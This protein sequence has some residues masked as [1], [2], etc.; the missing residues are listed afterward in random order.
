MTIKYDEY[1][2]NQNRYKL[3]SE[4]KKNQL[5]IQDKMH[6]THIIFVNP[7]PLSS[8]AKFDKATKSKVIQKRQKGLKELSSGYYVKTKSAQQHLKKLRYKGHLIFT[9]LFDMRKIYTNSVEHMSHQEISDKIGISKESLRKYLRQ[10]KTNGLIKTKGTNIYINPMIA[11]GT[12][13]HRKDLYCDYCNRPIDSYHKQPLFYFRTDAELK[14]LATKIINKYTHTY[15]ISLNSSAKRW[16]TVLN[17]VQNYINRHYTQSVKM[18]DYIFDYINT[19]WDARKK[20]NTKDNQSKVN[21]N[22][23]S[24][25]SPI[26][27]AYFDILSHLSNQNNTI[28]L[29]HNNIEEDLNLTTLQLHNVLKNLGNKGLVK[30]N[31]SN[32]YV[33]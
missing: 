25:L 24:S 9:E 26:Y 21:N 12:T 2:N 8:T 32:V 13:N 3:I 23:I 33:K 18:S 10:F 29:I 16:G 31:N 1:I 6:P 11:S 15:H 17:K 30:V 14:A 5:I 22:V 28:S 4:N 27:R 19:V 7:K 20:N